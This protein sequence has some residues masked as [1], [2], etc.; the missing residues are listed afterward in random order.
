MFFKNIQVKNNRVINTI[1]A[2]TFGVLL[3]HANSD[4]MRQWLWKDL[5]DVVGH[6]NSSLMPLYALGCV[7]AIFIVCVLID[8]IRINLIEKPFFR[9]WDKHEEGLIEKYKTLE[10]RIFKKFN[11]E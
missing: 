7:L 5:L 11:I 6:Y 8:I 3:I 10:S 1:A 9:W 2:S 4:T